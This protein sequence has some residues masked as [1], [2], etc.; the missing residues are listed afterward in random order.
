MLEKRL[1][2]IDAWC[3]HSKVTLYARYDDLDSTG[4]RDDRFDL[5]CAG[6]NVTIATATAAVDKVQ[7]ERLSAW[8]SAQETRA[9]MLDRYGHW[10]G[11]AKQVNK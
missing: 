7:Y 2:G 11:E 5:H 10:R 3:N 1:H 4:E 9:A 8:V 6:S